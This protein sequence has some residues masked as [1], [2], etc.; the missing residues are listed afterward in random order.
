M[1]SEYEGRDGTRATPINELVDALRPGWRV[2][3][4]PVGYWYFWHA[5]S[6]TAM[7]A[8]EQGKYS[9]EAFQAEIAVSVAKMNEVN[10]S[11]SGERQ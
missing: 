9:E 11:A 2:L 5:Q 7:W 10:S 4:A 8:P 3:L 6:Q 1:G